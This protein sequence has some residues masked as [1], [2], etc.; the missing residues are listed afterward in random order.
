MMRQMHALKIAMTD[1]KD[2]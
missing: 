1:L 2:N